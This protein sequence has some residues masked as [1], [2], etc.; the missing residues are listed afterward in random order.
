VHDLTS[1]VGIVAIAAGAVAVVGFLTS[2]VLAFRLSRVRSEQRAV[3]GDRREDL[4]AH[5][6]SLRSQFEALHQYVEDVAGRLDHRMTTAEQR[7]DGAIAYTSLVRYDAYGEMSG[8]QSM[9]IALLDSTSSGVVL[10]AIAH[11]DQAR[12]YAKQVQGGKGALEL[13]PEED[14][15][16]K[17]ALERGG[18]GRQ[19]RGGV[20]SPGAH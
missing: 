3:L 20:A 5:A 19:Q 17:L 15:A 8:H 4:V 14:E 10:S 18:E 1:T 13:S 11:R 7:L 6:A 16:I 9:S 12:L 2:V